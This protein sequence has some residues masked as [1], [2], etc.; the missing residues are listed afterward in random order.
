L[1]C[2][3]SLLLI[4]YINQLITHLTINNCLLLCDASPTLFVPSRASLGRQFNKECIYNKCYPRCVSSTKIARCILLGLISTYHAFCLR[5]FRF[6]LNPL[7]GWNA[8][9]NLS[10]THNPW[11]GSFSHV[12]NDDVVQADFY[13]SFVHTIGSYS[14]KIL[15]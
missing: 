4:Q 14:N 9:Q 15:L 12:G 3:N 7:A 8:F 13:C 11:L 1:V 5:R 10:F 2:C 6:L